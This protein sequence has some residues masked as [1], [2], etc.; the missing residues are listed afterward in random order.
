MK[1]IAVYHVPFE[2]LGSFATPLTDR[3]Y[4]ITYRHAGAAPLSHAE[5]CDTDLVIVLGGP[6]GAGDVGDYPWLADEITGLKRRLMLER[7]T[8]GICLGAQLMAVA[9]GGRVVRRAGTEIGWSCLDI[10]PKAGV[11]EALRAVAVLHWHGDNIVLPM[12]RVAVASTDGTP[13]QAFCVGSHALAMQF[14]AEF[15]TGAI[16][17][18]LTGHAVEL[19]QAGVDINRLRQDAHHFGGALADAGRTLINGWLSGLSHCSH[20]NQEQT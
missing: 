11:F 13:C 16:E 14:H 15:R 2:D 10:A 7:P 4:Q 3:G 6:V 5:W 19:A 18:W 12:G 1:C 17:E 20:S 8:L 9:L